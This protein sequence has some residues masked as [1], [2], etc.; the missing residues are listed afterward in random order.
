MVIC[1]LYDAT[2]KVAQDVHP[3]LVD[4]SANYYYYY[5]YFRAVHFR[6]RA[7]Y[8]TIAVQ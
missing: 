8:G 6:I 4:G 1:A 2:Y 5:Y 3:V 7:N